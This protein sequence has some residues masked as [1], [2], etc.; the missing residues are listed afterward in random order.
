MD[1]RQP[2]EQ[3]DIIF[4]AVEGVCG[5]QN[6]PM[7]WRCINA[8]TKEHFEGHKHPHPPQN[9]I[10]KLRGLL[11]IH[12][13]HPCGTQG[14]TWGA[15]GPF[16]LAAAMVVVVVTPVVFCSKAAKILKNEEKK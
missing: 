13:W 5:P 3:A 6:T 11:P 12:L 7:L 9:Y 10:C 16:L 4:G 8:R 14:L 15:S 2:P 1:G